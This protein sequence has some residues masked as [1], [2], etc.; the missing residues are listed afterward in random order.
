VPLEIACVAPAGCVLGE[1]PIWDEA[2]YLWW[3][4]IKGPAVHRYRPEG[5]EL[6][7]WPMP[8]PVGSIALRQKGGL[9]LA[10]QSGFA[11]FDPDTGDIQRLFDPEPEQPQN[12]LNDCRCDVQGRFWAGTMHDPEQE[13]TGNLFRLDP[14]LSLERFGMGF[15]VTN[16]PCWTGD[17]RIFYFNDSAERR[18][19][20][21]DFD[22][23]A[24]R[25]GERRLFAE[26]TPSEGH[27]D[28]QTVDA[29]DGLWTAH[30]TG[31]RVTRRRRD[32]AQDHEVL[33]PVPLVT[34]CCFGGEN[35][36]VL[37]VTTARVG[38]KPAALG[39]APLSGGLFAVRGLGVRGRPTPKFAG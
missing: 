28:G 38:L 23:K 33:L 1:G 4:D 2:G 11:I 27:P 31:G 35:L 26:F 32:G 3:V 8:E 39:A 20:A 14:D 5:G 17:G 25:L 30:W 21:Y 29:E 15:I 16:G 18:I 22:M 24:G 34:C 37:Y 10:L 9:I 36:D 7:S 13:P 19:W 12:R 6:R